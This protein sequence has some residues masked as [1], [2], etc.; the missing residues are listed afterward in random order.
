M[1]NVTLTRKIKIVCKI[2]SEHRSTKRWNCVCVNWFFIVYFVKLIQ[3][4]HFVCWL[5]VFSILQLIKRIFFGTIN[6]MVII[7]FYFYIINMYFVRGLF[8][9]KCVLRADFWFYNFAKGRWTIRINRIEL[10]TLGCSGKSKSSK[11]KRS[12]NCE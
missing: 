3:N 7:L 1:L 5:T 4:Q 6:V 8:F 2:Y 10:V 12:V 9:R 11:E